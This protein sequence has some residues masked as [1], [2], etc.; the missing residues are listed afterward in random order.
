M[1]SDVNYF[2]EIIYTNMLQIKTAP[3]YSSLRVHFRIPKAKKNRI[4]Q[5]LDSSGIEVFHRIH[6]QLPVQPPQNNK[7]L[8]VI[9]HFPGY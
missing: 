1:Y 9:L 7:L 6:I 8:I 4:F 5:P 2:Y 3:G